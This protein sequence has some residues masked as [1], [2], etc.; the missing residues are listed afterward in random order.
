MIGIAEAAAGSYWCR[1]SRLMPRP[2]KAATQVQAQGQ[3]SRIEMKKR[4]IITR[5]SPG[6]VNVHGR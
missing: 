2:Q 6:F 4:N 5:V 3:H 1:V